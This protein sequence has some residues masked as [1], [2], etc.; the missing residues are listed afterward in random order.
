[1]NALVRETTY[2]VAEGEVKETTT[3]VEMSFILTTS[4]EKLWVSHEHGPQSL[5]L[6]GMYEL[7]EKGN[8]W[9]MQYGTPP[10]CVEGRWG[11]RN[12]PHM[13]VPHAELV[14]LKQE[15]I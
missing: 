7:V 8:D 10:V 1:M 6:E 13:V 3:D 4:N 9:L 5:P 12:Y 15:I 14:K 2:H 11:G